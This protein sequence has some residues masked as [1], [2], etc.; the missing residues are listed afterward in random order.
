MRPWLS[1]IGLG[2]DGF[3]RL[4]P[5]ARALVEGAE[6]LV[7]GE[8]HLAMVPQAG[9]ERLGWRTPVTD[10]IA[11]I[12][13]RR[14]KRVVV[15]ATGDPM[16]Y[17]IGVTLARHVP[18]DEMTVI[19][20]PGAFSLVC[21][22]LGW[23][24]AAVTA[25]TLHGRPLEI[26]HLHLAPGARLLILSHDGTTP[27]A[28]ARRLSERGY[29]PS[30]ISVFEHM[31]GP[32]ERRIDGTAEDWGEAG[33]ADLNT[34]AVDC[35]AAPGTPLRPLVPGLPD[36]A[37]S[38]DG[39]ITKRELRAL[40]LAKLAPHAG[41]RLWDVGAGCG[42]IAVE[43]LRAAPHGA[44]DAVERDP[45]RCDLIARNAADLGVPHLNVVRGTAPEALAGLDPPDA[46]FIGGGIA[47]DGLVVAC[48]EA[49]APGG[50]LVA[51][52]VTEAGEAQVAQ[53]RQRLGGE[54]TRVAVSRLAPLGPHRAWQP[55]M[56]VTQF[57]AVKE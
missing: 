37:F 53:L 35:R 55:L 47:A 7:G 17:G 12:T 16:S 13:A 43:W 50:R 27:A 40:T 4:S 31:G 24:L 6:V 23:P 51:N 5:A 48:V 11:E 22:R 46:V 28:V 8:R 1:V 39:Q 34:I 30:R 9:A 29:G 57:A 3:E 41:A 15:L 20:A 2:E 33:C 56:P 26:L 25:L 21:A 14:D 44:A 32:A 36:D 49:L 45:A 54:L 38:H 10:T 42:S 52:V 18:M 19:P